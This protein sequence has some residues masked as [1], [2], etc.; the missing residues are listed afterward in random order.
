M[1]S[2]LSLLAYAKFFAQRLIGFGFP[3]ASMALAMRLHTKPA[4]AGSLALE[5]GNDIREIVPPRPRLIAI[6]ALVFGMLFIYLHL[7]LNRTCMYLCAP[8]RLPVSRQLQS[9][10]SG[11]APSVT[12][13]RFVLDVNSHP[14][15]IRLERDFFSDS[16]GGYAVRVTIKTHSEVFV[17]QR[18]TGLS[19]VGQGLGQRVQSL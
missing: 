7:E 3:V 19:R 4:G 14:E 1:P 18:G 17:N 12:G 5:E 11:P 13:R 9:L 2:D 6:A 16:P 15:I 10:L 8:L